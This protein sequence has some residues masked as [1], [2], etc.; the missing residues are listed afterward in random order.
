MELQYGKN[1]VNAA[2]TVQG[3]ERFIWST[4][5]PVKKLSKG[6]YTWMYHFDGKAAV[7]DYLL[8]EHK[9]LA[10]KTSFINIAFYAS[11]QLGGSMVAPKKVSY[12]HIS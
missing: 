5:P 10:K 4:L 9:D 1:V 7:K 6:K 2:A 8:K 11:N 3:L 12:L